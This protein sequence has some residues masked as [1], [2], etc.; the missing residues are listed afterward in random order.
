MRFDLVS[1]QAAVTATM[2][3]F[4]KVQWG[5]ERNATCAHMA[6]FHLER[7]GRR[8]E[9]LPRMRSALTARR[10]LNQRGWA[11][12][13]GWI[14]SM[15]LERIAPAMMLPGDIASLPTED[16]L[17]SIVIACGHHKVI[18]WREDQPGLV[19]VDVPLSALEKAWRV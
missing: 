19:V 12:V 13:A 5:W 8:T 14:D 4:A 16:G 9:A 10:V 2:A 17:G 3:K 1:R 18:G 11:D 7:C 6:R 15:G